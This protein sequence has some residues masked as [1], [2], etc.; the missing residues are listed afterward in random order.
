LEG[1]RRIEN[2]IYHKWVQTLNPK[3]IDPKLQ[4]ESVDL[5]QMG[6]NPQP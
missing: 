6:T 5:P 2:L 3:P 4:T 1:G